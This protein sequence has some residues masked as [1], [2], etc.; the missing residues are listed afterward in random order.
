MTA[1]A[2]VLV[3][4][5]VFAQ[6]EL[7]QA[8]NL[9]C[10]L[11][12]MSHSFPT[13]CFATCRDMRA[14]WLLL[15]AS[16]FPCF[17]EASTY[18]YFVEGN[19]LR[20]SD[21]LDQRDNRSMDVIFCRA[22]GSEVI[23]PD[24][25]DP[26]CGAIDKGPDYGSYHRMIKVIAVDGPCTLTTKSRGESLVGPGVFAAV[27][28]LTTADACGFANSGQAVTVVSDSTYFRVVDAACGVNEAARLRLERA[29]AIAAGHTVQEKVAFTLMTVSPSVGQHQSTETSGERQAPARRRAIYLCPA[30]EPS[31]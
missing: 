20:T 25:Y 3:P 21:E 22:S 18:P 8:C 1:D 31:W 11:P 6:T 26:S 12:D 10:L 7:C 2:R 19:F 24:P 4:D 5:N 14:W 17:T 23:L 15:A 9:S 27:A 28:T 16:S 30:R 13:G 29:E